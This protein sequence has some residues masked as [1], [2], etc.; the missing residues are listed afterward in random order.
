MHY[1]LCEDRELEGMRFVHTNASPRFS[2]PSS[3]CKRGNEYANNLSFT[4][5]NE[6]PLSS[7]K[8]KHIAKRFQIYPQ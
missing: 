4:A 3:C 1:G 2:R 7:S 5:S 6:A 8:L